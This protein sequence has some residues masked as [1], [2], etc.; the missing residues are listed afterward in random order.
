MLLFWATVVH[1]SET[2]E[3]FDVFIGHQEIHQ[4]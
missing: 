3:L 1:P 4:F 2:S